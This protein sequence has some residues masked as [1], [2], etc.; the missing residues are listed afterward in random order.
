MVPDLTA[1]NGAS[2][3]THTGRQTTKTV[4]AVIPTLTETQMIATS[5]SIKRKLTQKHD[6]PLNRTHS[7]LAPRPSCWPTRRVSLT[8]AALST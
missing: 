1:R 5:P 8:L 7:R 6:N 2:L 3:D 4:M